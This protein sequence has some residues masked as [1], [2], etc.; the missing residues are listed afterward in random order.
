M[1][2]KLFDPITSIKIYNAEERYG[3]YRGTTQG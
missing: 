1:R 3:G 2:N